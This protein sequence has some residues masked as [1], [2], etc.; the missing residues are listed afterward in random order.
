MTNERDLSTLHA[1]ADGE[2][3]PAERDAA[4][5]WVAEDADAAQEYATL[6][7][8]KAA[9]RGLPP[10]NPEPAVWRACVGRLNE[11]D[12]AR[13]TESFVGRYAWALCSLVFALIVG[14]G[15]LTRM[16]GRHLGTAELG[17]AA[18]QLPGISPV[19]H[20]TASAV[21]GWMSRE[22]GAAPV[23]HL[24]ALEVVQAV[25]GTV[26]GQQLAVLNLRDVIGHMT[27]YVVRNGGDLDGM[28]PMAGGMMSGR[29]GDRNCV[30]WTSG[31]FTLVLAG[32]R[33]AEE[34]SAIGSTIAVH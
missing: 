2:L 4:L 23:G 16:G 14:G 33:S 15:L 27:L 31:P 22:L 11:I 26:N 17:A 6:M 34:L 28:S 19:A 3:T 13:K 10:A 1:L 12:R 25:A 20:P 9:L 29:I 30:E 5:A 21:P 7:R 18:F 32:D 24:G 8:L